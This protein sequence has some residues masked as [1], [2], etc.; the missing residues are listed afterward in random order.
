MG[1]KSLSI[2][3]GIGI[4]VII[5]W[6]FVISPELKTTNELIELT[7]ESTGFIKVVDNF[8]EPLSEPI[9]MK[10]IWTRDITEKIGDTNDSHCI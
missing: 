9:K 8:G 3:I 1:S 4:F 7:S 2:N 6:M 5:L 10:F